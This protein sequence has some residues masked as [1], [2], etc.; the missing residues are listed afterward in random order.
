MWN[1]FYIE[2][3]PD[4]GKDWIIVF[5]RNVDTSIYRNDSTF[6]K[7][8]IIQSGPR[9]WLHFYIEMIP[10]F[11][12]KQCFHIKCV[13]FHKCNQYGI[14][15]IAVIDASLWIHLQESEFSGYINIPWGSIIQP[16]RYSW[17]DLLSSQLYWEGWIIVWEFYSQTPKTWSMFERRLHF[18]WEIEM[19]DIDCEKNTDPCPI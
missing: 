11:L 3:Q 16:H 1:H 10:H 15:S 14:N 9:I 12:I 17:H 6:L 13:L 5:S 7:K 8:T 19:A 4:F 18:H 2:M